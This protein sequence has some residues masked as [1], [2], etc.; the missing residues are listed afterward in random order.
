MP[1]TTVV[2]R[3]KAYLKARQKSVRDAMKEL[4]LDALM[5]THPPDLAYLTNFTGDDSVGLITEKDFFLATDFRYQ[6]QADQEAGWLKQHIREA[7][8][9][10]TLVKMLAEAKV[11]RIGFE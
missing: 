4:S 7:K 3:A 8:M 2:S 1:T 11:K 5:L 6:E 10:D 9:S